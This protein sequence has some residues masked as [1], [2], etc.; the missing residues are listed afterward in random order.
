MARIKFLAKNG[1]EEEKKEESRKENVEG[2]V[3]KSN[4]FLPMNL[5]N[6][7]GEYFDAEGIEREISKVAGLKEKLARGFFSRYYF[8]LF[9]LI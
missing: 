2:F 4:G 5:L 1:F 9:Q 7:K 3:R 8:G 6:P